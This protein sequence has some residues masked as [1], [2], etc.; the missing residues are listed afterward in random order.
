[1]PSCL[2]VQNMSYLYFLENLRKILKINMFR[3][4]KTLLTKKLYAMISTVMTKLKMWQM[5][6]A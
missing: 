1:M 4:L 3:T 6:K 5:C 2:R